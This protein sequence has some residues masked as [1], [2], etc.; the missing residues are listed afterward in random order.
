MSAGASPL[1]S[2]SASPG[3]SGR[4]GIESCIAAVNLVDPN[5]SPAERSRKTSMAAMLPLVVL[6]FPVLVVVWALRLSV[7]GPGA[8]FVIVSLTP[9]PFLCV[10]LYL[11]VKVS[12]TFPAALAEVRIMYMM[13]AL[14]AIQ[15]TFPTFT[16][17][18]LMFTAGVN[19]ITTDARP[20]PLLIH[21][22]TAAVIATVDA[23]N[24]AVL[25]NA[26]AQ[27][28]S[29]AVI[30]L[31]SSRYQPALLTPGS[32]YVGPLTE[33]LVLQFASVAITMTA[34]ALVGLIHRRHM[35]LLEERQR[36][37][38][39]A[40]EL[41]DRVR[42]GDVP[43]VQRLLSDYSEEPAHNPLLLRAFGHLAATL[44][45]YETRRPP[46]EREANWQVSSVGT[47]GPAGELT[48]DSRCPVTG[49]WPNALAEDFQRQGGMPHTLRRVDSTGG[50][51]VDVS[52]WTA[53][54]ASAL[55]V[56]PD[57]SP[58]SG[59]LAPA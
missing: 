32:V 55:M 1:G 45:E 7:V 25:W 54:G 5:D 9:G 57:A 26:V 31:N 56:S 6:G 2:R 46:A 44:E 20:V 13:I 14:L 52:E 41:S 53:D 49:Q 33:R 42:V 36:T 22:V 40:A 8:W 3:R 4:G 29:A 23:Y 18:G 39:L 30:G 50:P 17:L 58:A 59:P 19:S 35:S 10:A 37:A 34:I 51:A 27:A 48:A 47:E 12:G 21:M 24:S 43:A 15:V 28:P 16:G 38:E 11:Y